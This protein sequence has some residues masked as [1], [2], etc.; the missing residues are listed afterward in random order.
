MTCQ[1]TGSHTLNHD[2]TWLHSNGKGQ[3]SELNFLKSKA[4]FGL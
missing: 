2:D 3:L 4:E 1:P